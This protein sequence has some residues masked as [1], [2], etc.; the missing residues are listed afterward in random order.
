MTRVDIND[1]NQSSNINCSNG[2]GKFVVIPAT[3]FNILKAKI[4]GN[5]SKLWQ[6]SKGKV[7]GNYSKLRQHSKGKIVGI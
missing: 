7:V 6:H 4:M 5:Y 1:N 3:S 2:S